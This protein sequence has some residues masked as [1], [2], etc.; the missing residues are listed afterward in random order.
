M[1]PGL[2]QVCPWGSST[3]RLIGSRVRSFWRTAFPIGLQGWLR[4]AWLLGRFSGDPSLP[5]MIQ[6]IFLYGL[7][8]VFNQKEPLWYFQEVE[9]VK[10]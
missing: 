8:L 1:T 6:D 3:H 10:D 2:H 5:E 7:S 4:S 9:K